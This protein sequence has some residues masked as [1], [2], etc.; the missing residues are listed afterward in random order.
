MSKR[1]TTE[2]Y[3]DLVSKIHNFEFDYSD[4]VFTKM[5]EHIEIRCKKHGIF[6]QSAD[7]HKNGSKCP[8][9]TNKNK[10]TTF[11]YLEKIYQRRTIFYDYSRLVYIDSNTKVEIGCDL[12][13][14]FWQNPN[15]HLTG[16]N[17]PK[18]AKDSHGSWNL[19]GKEK[20]IEELTPDQLKNDYSKFIYIN[21]STK[22]EIICIK[23]GSFWQTPNDHRQGHNCPKC[24]TIK[25]VDTNIRKKFPDLL[26]EFKEKH[27]ESFDY[28]KSIFI[29]MHTPIE[30]G[31]YKHGKFLQK[32]YHHR[33]G[34]KCPKCASH[35]SKPEIE[36][37][38][39]IRE[40]G[41]EILTSNRNIIKPYE[42][43]IYIPELKKAIEFNGTYWH[44]SEKYFIPG[45]HSEKSNLCREKGIQLLHIREDLWKKDPEKMIEVIQRFIKDEK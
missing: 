14:W 8:K 5:R 20:F 4:S 2:T 25:N 27:G 10:M 9:C 3:I 38:N 31:C 16:H 17:C 45:K 26:L 11:E 42:L 39:H 33:N 13:G 23:H 24:A 41:F 36:V 6:K 34:S 15:N 29:D 7:N 21:S 37:A 12:H 28:G 43:D 32:P 40:I 22:G 30:I 35:I 44:Y 19:L 18:C 1:Y